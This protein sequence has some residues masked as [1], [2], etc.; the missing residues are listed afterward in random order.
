MTLPHVVPA[1]LAPFFQE[2]DLAQ[3]KPERDAATIIERTL[4][5]GTR[6]E[7]Q[8]LFAEFSR[9]QIRAWIQAWGTFAL[10]EPHL[11]FWRLVLEME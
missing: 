1:S 6:E 2:Y 10:P 11:S 7:L 5:F 9:E 8:W 4:R 3:L